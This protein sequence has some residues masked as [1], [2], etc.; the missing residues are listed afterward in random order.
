MVLESWR[1]GDGGDVQDD[2]LPELLHLEA[3]LGA[4]PSRQEHLGAEAG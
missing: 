1:P 2:L 3:E 4:V